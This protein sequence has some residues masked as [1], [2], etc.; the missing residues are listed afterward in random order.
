MLEARP[1]KNRL[2]WMQTESIDHSWH[3][4]GFVKRAGRKR[5]SSTVPQCP[6]G[7]YRIW[8]A[9]IVNISNHSCVYNLFQYG[10]M[11]PSFVTHDSLLDT[12]QY[13]LH[14]M[15]PGWLRI[16]AWVRFLLMPRQL[17]PPW[18]PKYFL[19]FLFFRDRQLHCFR[20]KR[21]FKQMG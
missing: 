7:K 3:W 6:E 4:S 20:N 18:D 17:K 19:G 10:L 13:W 21:I 2:S 14:A 5:L 8:N 11:N 1:Y 12:K 9:E 16:W 15:D